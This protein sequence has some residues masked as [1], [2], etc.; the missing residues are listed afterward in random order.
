MLNNFLQLIKSDPRIEAFKR[1]INIRLQFLNQYWVRLTKREQQLIYL[2]GVTF[3]IFIFVSIISALVDKNIQMHQNVINLEMFSQEVTAK[4]REFK[5]IS[6]IPTAK[7]SEVKLDQIKDDM[8]IAFGVDV[9]DVNSSEG[10][11]SI[12]VQ[13]VEFTKVVLFIDQLRKNYGLFPKQLR[14]TASAKA[15]FVSFS[16]SF[17]QEIPGA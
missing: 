2:A 13:E 1:D 9:P 3:G 12:N 10:I 8:K 11:I 17:D 5:N 4:A 6:K 7:F 15:G 14:I 16:A